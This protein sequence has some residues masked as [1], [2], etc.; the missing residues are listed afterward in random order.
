MSGTVV[1]KY[2][3]EGT[4]EDI[5][6]VVTEQEGGGESDP[7]KKGGNYLAGIVV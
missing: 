7:T 3:G 5:Y 1:S 4:L 6:L 2:L